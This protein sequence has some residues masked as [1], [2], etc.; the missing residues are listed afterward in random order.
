M[1]GPCTFSPSPQ[2]QPDLSRDIEG[3]EYELQPSSLPRSRA[4]SYASKNSLWNSEVQANEALLPRKGWTSPEGTKFTPAV[5]QAAMATTAGTSSRKKRRKLQGWKFGVAVSSL[6]AF[7]VLL[8]NMIITIY[9]GVKFESN[10]GVGTAFDGDCERVAAWTTGLHVLINGLS[11]ILLSASNY[12]MQCLSS[13]TRT[14]IDRAHARGDWL[15]IGIVSVRN[16]WRIDWRRTV[17]WWA[18]AL[19]SVPIHLL[20]NSAVFKTLAANEYVLVIA[21]KDFLQGGEFAPYYTWNGSTPAVMNIYEYQRTRDVQLRLTEHEDYRNETEV[22]NLTTS[23]CIASYGTSFLSEYRNV[24]AITSAQGNQTNN[25]VFWT[26]RSSGGSGS[27]SYSWICWDADNKPFVSGCDM[28]TVRETP[29]DWTLARYKID[30]C[31]AQVAQPHCKLQFSIHILATVIVMNACKSICMF[32]ALWRQKSAALVTVG[33]AMSSFLDQPDASTEG[34]CLMA[35]TDLDRDFMGWKWYGTVGHSRKTPITFR[36]PMRRRLFAAASVTRWCIT[37][38]LCLA[39]LIAATSLLDIGVE[40]L[41]YSSPPPFEMGLGAVD[42]RALLNIGLPQRGSGGLVSAVLV[43]NLPQ[44]IISFIYLTYNGLFTSLCL[45]H[46]YSSYGLRERKKPLRVTTPHGQQR[47]SYYLHLPFRYAVPLVV[48][49]ATL[50]WLI[51]QSIFLARVYVSDY[52]GQETDESNLSEIGYSCLPILL[53]ILLGIAMLVTVLW[54]GC[55]KFPS[56]MPVVGS[57]SVALAAAAHRPKDDVDA[58]FLPVQW[59]EVRGEG[60]DE[61]GHCCF[62][63]QEVHDLTPGR[64][65]AGAARKPYNDSSNA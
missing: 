22:H 56:S 4:P 47:S 5:T 32:L 7:T 33:D 1:A 10:G 54:Y 64:R 39:A 17:L 28:G 58:A 19:S 44:A 27:Q 60:T 63:S 36:R 42:S 13:P 3:N 23:E 41:K 38:G 11:S 35:K 40:H 25:T 61:I 51:S 59:G 46:E 24:I 49:S 9:A 12:T 15:D 21:N 55:R 57:C 8:L 20:Y 37:I 43:A 26:T 16:L 50:H 34:C 6:T 65:Y 30:Y 52:K 48:A 18:L 53:A 62:T 14:E 45:A 2:H 31:L 29:S